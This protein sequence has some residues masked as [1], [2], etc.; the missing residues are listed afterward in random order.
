MWTV[1]EKYWIKQ[2]ETHILKIYNVFLTEPYLTSLAGTT[3]SSATATGWPICL[4]D[5]QY[6][7]E[8]DKKCSAFKFAQFDYYHCLIALNV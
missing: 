2:Q 8:T 4:Y 7:I 6:A 3:V 1:C 5:C